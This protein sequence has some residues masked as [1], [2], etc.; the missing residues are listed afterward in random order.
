MESG[1]PIPVGNIT[2]G[3]VYYDALVSE[4]GCTGATDTLQCLRGVPYDQLLAAVNQ[5]PGIFSYQVKLEYCP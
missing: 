2:E 4:T 1:S 3:Q 5:S